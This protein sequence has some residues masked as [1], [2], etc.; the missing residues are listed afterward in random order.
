MGY[1]EFIWLIINL[2]SYS[3]LLQ[4]MSYKAMLHLTIPPLLGQEMAHLFC[5]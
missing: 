5:P 2:Y 1:I 3:H 4:T